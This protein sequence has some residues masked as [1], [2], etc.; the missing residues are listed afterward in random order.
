MEDIYVYMDIVRNTNVYGY[1][2]HISI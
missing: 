2:A 1:M